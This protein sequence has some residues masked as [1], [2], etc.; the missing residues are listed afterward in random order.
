M[1]AIRGTKLMLVMLVATLSFSWAM[2]KNLG[3]PGDKERLLNELDVSSVTWH[4]SKREA[5]SD[6]TGAFCYCPYT[7]K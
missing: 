5:G 7:L 4:Y 3:Q 2:G 6:G 1:S